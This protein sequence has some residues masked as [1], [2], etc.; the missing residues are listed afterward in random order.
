MRGLTLGVIAL[1]AL[2]GAASAEGC[3]GPGTPLFH[4]TLNGG[5]KAVDVCLQDDV[6]YYRFG[7]AGGAADI[8]LARRAGAVDMRPWNG[9]GR[10]I[11]E[12]ATFSN[13]GYD[14]TV[15][16]AIDRLTQAHEVTG[17]VIVTRGGDELA[18]L[19]CDAGA[20]TASDIYPL[21]EAKEAAGQ[22]WNREMFRWGEC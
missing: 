6:A 13:G 18:D 8:L 10:S 5:T 19:S 9:V 21:F 4:C 20:V 2:A 15:H 16:Y 17:G 11:F 7:P 14:Y 12:T 1:G 3:F 22:C